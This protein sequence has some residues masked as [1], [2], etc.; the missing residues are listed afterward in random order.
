[1]ARMHRHDDGLPG[2]QL[3]NAG[4]RVAGDGFVFAADKVG[5]PLTVT[6]I[7]AAAATI[8]Y[9]APSRGHAA[10][11]GEWMVMLATEPTHFAA[12]GL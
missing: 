11:D 5:P 2:E 6:S 12:I 9:D 10:E 1:M 3:S 8:R 7:D 4:Q